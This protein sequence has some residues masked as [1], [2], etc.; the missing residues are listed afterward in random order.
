[1]LYPAIMIGDNYLFTGWVK[2]PKRQW[3]K[4]VSRMVMVGFVVILTVILEDKLDKFLAILGS[5]TCTPIAFMFP[6]LF[7]FKCCAETPKQ[8]CIDMII[9]AFGST[10]MVF[11][12]GLGLLN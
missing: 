7:H 6:A 10:V 2:S 11:C 12:T 3:G 5:L 1:M 8:K 4:N 9:F